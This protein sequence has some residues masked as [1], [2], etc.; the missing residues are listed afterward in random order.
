MLTDIII[1]ELAMF[2]LV[3]IITLLVLITIT[4]LT[5]IFARNIKE[6]SKTYKIVRIS[7]AIS[8]IV[9]ELA[10]YGWV[11]FNQKRSLLDINPIGGFCAMT[12]ILTIMYLL[13]NNK[14]MANIVFYY[15]FTGA[16]FALI[17]VD[18]KQLPPHFRFFH[19]FYIHF[20]FML[21]A[22][23]NYVIGRVKIER[24]AFNQAALYLF[25]YTIFIFILGTIFN[26]NWFYFKESPV[27]E[28]SD[29]FGKFWYPP[30]W[31]L[32]IYLLINVWY[33]IFKGIDKIRKKN[34]IVSQ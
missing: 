14:K 28:I 22:I 1:K 4:I 31:I 20:T 5:I 2:D 13:T 10:Y 3:H 26:Q 25:G 16:F 18:I 32:T 7:V 34:L 27:K 24:K 11:L 29:F 17:F 15:T 21:V 6:D 23:Y 8:L 12:N 9:F 33:F 19:Y 30:L